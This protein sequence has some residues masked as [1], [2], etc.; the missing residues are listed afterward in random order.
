MTRE[1]STRQEFTSGPIPRHLR[2][3]LVEVRGFPVPYVAEWTD[4]GPDANLRRDDVRFARLD[5]REWGSP[6][7]SVVVLDPKGEQGKGAAR[8]ARLHPG[9]QR[10][11][12][13]RRLC[14]V[15][16]L[17]ADPKETLVFV[18]GLRKDGLVAFREPGMHRRCA[19]FA[20][21]ACPGINRSDVVV[22]ESVTYEILPSSMY[23]NVD[24]QGEEDHIPARLGEWLP[25]RVGFLAGLWAKLPDDVPV[26]DRDEWRAD[27]EHLLDLSGKRRPRVA[28][29]R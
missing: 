23:V 6:Y 28:R 22:I 7:E 5:L 24:A 16:G 13:L 3:L 4:E 17:K 21:F 8:L 25:E 15:C 9:R 2:R 19:A 29:T 27:H 10:E 18:G 1:L 14:Q 20:L 12:L 26:L 11:C